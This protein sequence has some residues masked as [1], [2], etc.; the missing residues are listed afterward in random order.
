MEEQKRWKG[1]S[2][3]FLPYYFCRVVS[4]RISTGNCHLQNWV[5]I[6]TLQIRLAKDTLLTFVCLF[7][8]KPRCADRLVFNIP[9]RQPLGNEYTHEEKRCKFLQ[10]IGREGKEKQKLEKLLFKFFV[11]PRGDKLDTTITQ[12][13]PVI[14]LLSIYRANTNN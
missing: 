11:L 2:Q 13:L 8:P 4:D 7:V 5:N 14:T 1:K 12:G 10:E 9:F 3:F 6:R